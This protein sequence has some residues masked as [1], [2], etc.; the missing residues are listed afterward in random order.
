[1]SKHESATAPAN[2]SK[3]FFEGLSVQLWLE[4][5]P[6]EHTEQEADRI[7]G[8]L[9]VP[10]GSSATCASCRGRNDSTVPFALAT[11]SATSTTTATRR[12][13]AQWLRHSNR[14]DAFFSR[15][16]WCSNSCWGISR[17]DC[18]GRS[19]RTEVRRGSHRAY[20]FG[21]LLDLLRT[22]GFDDVGVEEP[23]SRGDAMTTFVATRR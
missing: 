3:D 17:I 10:R 23:W 8:A 21:E 7:A 1:M 6:A 13:S 15:R 20:R 22:S 19:G 2:W 12:F 11:A 5:V 16:R 4:A 14:A 9:A 18:G